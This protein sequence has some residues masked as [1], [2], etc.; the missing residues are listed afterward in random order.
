MMPDADAANVYGTR[1]LDGYTV[2]TTWPSLAA[3]YGGVE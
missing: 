1:R 2:E 3:M